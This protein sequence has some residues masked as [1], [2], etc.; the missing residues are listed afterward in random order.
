MQFSCL[1]LVVLIWIALKFWLKNKKA[2]RF[3]LPFWILFNGI[4]LILESF[5]KIDTE[6]DS[7]QVYGQLVQ[8]RLKLMGEYALTL[9][10]GVIMQTELIFMHIPFYFI[11]SMI[12]LTNE[13]IFIRKKSEN[14]DNLIAKILFTSTICLAS[15]VGCRIYQYNQAK[16]LIRR[17]MQKASVQEILSKLNDGIIIFSRNKK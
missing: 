8:L 12:L 11:S 16:L 9:F 4:F 15:L 6:T 10:S 13:T 2:C 17:E 1:I 7:T 14:D 3:L 5:E